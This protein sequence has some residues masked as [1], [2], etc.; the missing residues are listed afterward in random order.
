MSSGLMLGAEVPRNFTSA[1]SN[2]LLAV[3]NNGERAESLLPNPTIE[4]LSMLELD[5]SIDF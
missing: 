1:S 4:Y 2:A 5:K 3:R